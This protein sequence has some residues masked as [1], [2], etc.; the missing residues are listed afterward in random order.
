MK[1]ISIDQ[2]KTM[3]ETL[4]LDCAVCHTPIVRGDFDR[5][6]VIALTGPVKTTAAH[7]RHF[8]DQDEA[9]RFVKPSVEYQRSLRLLSWSHVRREIVLNSSGG[10]P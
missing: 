1:P 10:R 7:L 8:Y 6:D 3:L 9:G 2:L 5:G 4:D